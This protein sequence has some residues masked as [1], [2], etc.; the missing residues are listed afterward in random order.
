MAEELFPDQ[1]AELLAQLEDRV[2][3]AL[4]AVASLKKENQALKK[5]IQRLESELATVKSKNKSAA[6]RI[7]KLLEQMELPGE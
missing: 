5:D 6:S 4:E 1:E 7:T 2:V 3:K